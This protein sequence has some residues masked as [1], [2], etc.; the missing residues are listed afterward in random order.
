MA[1]GSMAE[2]AQSDAGSEGG[3]EAVA[4]D[5]RTIRILDL[6]FREV[7]HRARCG[8]SIREVSGPGAHMIFDSDVLPQNFIA[9]AVVITGDP[10]NGEASV[11][12]IGECRKGAEAGA[13][14]HRFPFEPEIE[15]VA[16]D[17]QRSRSGCQS[18]QETDESALRLERRDAKVRIGDDV[19]RRGQHWRIVVTRHGLHKPART[20]P[21]I[22]LKAR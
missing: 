21:S 7:R 18:P 13:G 17:H 16:V 1:L 2:G 15:Q 4:H 12:K 14:N 9:P 3:M 11:S 19:T 5:R 8:R 22:Y 20:G 10:E 6:L